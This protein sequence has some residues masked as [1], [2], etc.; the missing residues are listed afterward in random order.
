MEISESF[1]WK[2]DGKLADLRILAPKIFPTKQSIAKVESRVQT[3]ATSPSTSS[4]ERGMG[5]EFTEVTI[6]CYSI[7]TANIG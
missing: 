5:S 2:K 7:S 6:D 1:F 4:Y 3:G